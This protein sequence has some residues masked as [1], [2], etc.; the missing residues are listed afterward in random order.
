MADEVLC[1]E[2]LITLEERG[3]GITVDSASQFRE[4]A[5]LN[6]GWSKTQVKKALGSLIHRRQVRRFR[7]EP[8]GCGD[9]GQ[10]TTFRLSQS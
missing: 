10:P 4:A 1:D 5:G 6:D 3:G 2:I 7:A 8:Q 9:M